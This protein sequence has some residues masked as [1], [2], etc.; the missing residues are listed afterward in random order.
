M[1]AF[2]QS[3]YQK[4]AYQCI[5]LLTALF[6][7]CRAAKAVLEQSADTR[8]KWQWAVEWL[9][10]ELEKGGGRG[11]A[12]GQAGSGTGGGG[13]GSGQYS[14][15]NWS[16]PAQSNET[17]NGYFLERSLSARH[18]LDKACELLPEEEVRT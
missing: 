4:R 17:A 13:Q 2:S 11:G 18:T 6:S 10:D 9:N 15:T 8:R 16:P 7:T 1:I 12:G 3:H 5:K 14:Y